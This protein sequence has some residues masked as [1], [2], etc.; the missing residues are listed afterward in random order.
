MKHLYSAWN[1]YFLCT[2]SLY[3]F[4]KSFTEGLRRLSVWWFGN[5]SFFRRA[6][7]FFI[8]FFVFSLFAY[9]I[10][11]LRVHKFR[12]WDLDALGFIIFLEL[13]VLGI[14]K[15]Y[16]FTGQRIT[17]FFAPFVFY[18]IVKGINSLNSKKALCM[19]LRVFYACFLLVCSLNSL[20]VY[21]K[22]YN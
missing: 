13:F 8:P 10:K 19:S 11:S 16:P 5:S 6:A 7:S 18:L 1:D 15:K 20:L 14:M 9:G 4:M 12:L 17:L 3:C 21:L 2:D 22:L